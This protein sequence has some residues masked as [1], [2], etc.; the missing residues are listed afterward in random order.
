MQVLMLSPEAP[1]PLNGGGAFRTASLVHFFARFAA[2]DLILMS[3]H[4][5]PALPSGLVRNQHTI[6]LPEHGRGRAARYARNARRSIS[7]VPPLIDRFAGFERQI[8]EAVAGR[9]YDLGVVEHFWCAPYIHQMERFCTR[10]VLDLHNIESVLHERCAGMGGEKLVRF[11]HRRFAGAAQRLESTLLPRYSSILTASAEDARR[12]REL[13]P[14]AQV[15]VYPNALPRVDLPRSREL[16]W[17]V[18]SANFEYHP[19]IDAVQ[20]LVREIWPTVRMRNPELRLRLV[21]RN[22]AF[23]RHLLPAGAEAETGIEV[24]G[25]VDDALAEIA[26]ARLVVAPL[27][28]GSGTRLKILEAWAAGRCVLATS[29]AAEGLEARDGANIAIEDD[30]SSFAARLSHLAGDAAERA[31][32]GAAGRRTFEDNYSWQRAW[33]SL[34]IDLQL[35]HVSGLNGYTGNF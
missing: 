14:A 17:V 24:T 27:R 9:Q 6:R 25:P 31:R 30:P 10:T 13:A 8:E 11:G 22:D 33:E 16:P 12:V 2:V 29:L 35:T 1:Y 3:L 15:H 32:L 18:F 7:G 23:I 4:E 28:A 5:A 21:G 34:N 26:Q 20:F 19:N